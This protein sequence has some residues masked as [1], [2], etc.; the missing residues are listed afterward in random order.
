MSEEIAICVAPAPGEKQEEKYPGELDVVAELIRC[1]EMG[2]AIGH[3]HARDQNLL[4][5]VDVTW[6]RRQVKAIRAAC[7]LIIEGSTGGAPEPANAAVAN[8]NTSAADFR[9][10]MV[11]RFS[12]PRRSA[13]GR[14][15]SM[16]FQVFLL[17][18]TVE[19]LL[20]GV[21]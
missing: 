3:L 4:Q 13:S 11:R 20:G 12:L 10:R 8:N 17:D 1:H 18:Q 19:K 21:Q 9:V 5:T 6:F 15:S 16:Q 2:A 7:P 14:R